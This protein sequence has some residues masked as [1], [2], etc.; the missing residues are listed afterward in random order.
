MGL[1][2]PVYLPGMNVF[3]PSII[4]STQTQAADALSASAQLGEA[5]LALATSGADGWSGPA[6]TAADTLR[7]ALAGRT[8]A[9]CDQVECLYTVLQTA[10]DDKIARVLGASS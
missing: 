7:L 3:W 6:A 5:R 2:E 8:S 1:P 9:V 10:C 4:D